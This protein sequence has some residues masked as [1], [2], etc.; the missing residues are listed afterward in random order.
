MRTLKA[1]IKNQGPLT[2]RESVVLKFLCEG[3]M[4]KEI[5][6][7]VFRSYGCISKQVE[8]IATKL[9]ARS[10]TEIVMIAV[11]A[12]LVEISIV[13]QA[14][15]LH[16]LKNLCLVFLIIGQL[17]SPNLGRRPPQTP[18]PMVRL[19]RTSRVG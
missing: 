11:A 13:D 6:L 1:E 3:Y 18:R 10:T 17:I 14:F 19:V 15:E 9:N 8:S 4:R 2:A 7:R 5:A 12:G 16:S